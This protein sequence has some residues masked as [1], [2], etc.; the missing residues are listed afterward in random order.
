MSKQLAQVLINR[1]NMQPAL[2]SP[3]HA[4]LLSDAIRQFA[5]SDEQSEQ[6][7]QKNVGAELL[8]SYGYAP[9]VHDKPF[10]YAD[11]IAFIPI[12]GLLIN[13]FS[14]SWGWV[15]GYNFIRNQLNAALDDSDVK[16]IV[17]DCH[18]GGGEVAGCFELATEIRASRDMKPSLAVVDSA[19]YSACYA[20]A[21]SASKVAVI[22]SGGV[23]SIGVVAMHI[24]FSKAMAE[25]GVK[26]TY[27]FSGDHKVDGNPYE[28]LPAPVRKSIQ[29]RVDN[30]RQ[31][32]VNLVATNRG[33]DPKVVF[34][35]EA[36]CYTAAEGLDLG[37]IDAVAKPLEAVQ[38][39]IIELSRSEPEKETD[40]STA[41]KTGG[42]STT[43]VAA[44]DKAAADKAA[45][46]KAAAP[47]STAPAATTTVDANA[48]RQ[49]ER[50]RMKAIT[51]HANAKDRP[52]LANHIALNTNLS[53]DDAV[54]ML[55]AAPV[56]KAAD[57]KASAFVAAMNAQGGPEVGAD[58]A[59]GGELTG[60]QQIMKS[61]ELMTG[62]KE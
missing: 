53:V 35:T 59:A 1:F 56:E 52:A 21:S 60:A 8:A 37:L 44:A 17:F 23:G 42:E 13:R 10:V 12:T 24:D 9:D 38:A 47:A 30:T 3:A 61:Y 40:M 41:T 7:Q 15:T 16:A 5:E 19:S 4:S 48:E 55:A 39:F 33:L 14:Y 22:P 6:R 62:K 57:G 45:A 11:G 2:L 28:P 32:F 31:E 26:V 54:A 51:S 18:S 36:A 58:T 50:D 49:A 46:D 29:A 34:D 20:L 25:W 27:I 43:D